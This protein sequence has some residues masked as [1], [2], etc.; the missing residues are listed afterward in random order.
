[1]P[2]EKVGKDQIFL[3]VFSH[4]GY[5]NIGLVMSHASH[6]E[7]MKFSTKAYILKKEQKK[8]SLSD[9]PVIKGETCNKRGKVKSNQQKHTQNLKEQPH[10]IDRMRKFR[11]IVTDMIQHKTEKNR[12]WFQ[13]PV[14]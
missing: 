2:A 6:W 10:T 11:R 3:Y 4:F 12:I 9:W 13:Y 5:E 1:M 8:K 14:F 7:A